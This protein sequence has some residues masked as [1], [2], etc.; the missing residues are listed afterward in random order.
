MARENL[1]E[2]KLNNLTLLLTYL[3]PYLQANSRISPAFKFPNL[4][5]STKIVL[6]VNKMWNDGRKLKERMLW[7]K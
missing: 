3:L 4:Q 5:V 2:I 7:I 1:P 6:V